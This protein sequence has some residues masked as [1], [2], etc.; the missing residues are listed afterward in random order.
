MSDS[1]SEHFL[2]HY[3]LKFKKKNGTNIDNILIEYILKY[4]LL[5]EIIDKVNKKFVN[6]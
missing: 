6:F 1:C 2:L 4:I 3:N 5:E